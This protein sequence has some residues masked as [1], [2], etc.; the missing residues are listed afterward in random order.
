MINIHKGQEPK[1]LTE[2]RHTAAATYDD[3][4]DKDTLRQF[5]VAE[6]RGLCCYC[7]RSISPHRNAMKIE[8]WHPQEDPR[9]DHEQL[10]YRNLLA[11]C[12][13][14]DGYRRAIRHCDTAKGA[15]LLSRNPSSAVE[16]FQ[17]MIQYDLQGTI[18]ATD[19]V[20]SN[21][22]GEV[23]NL[24]V[25]ELKSIRRAELRA[26]L[27]GVKIR[28]AF[29]KQQLRKIIDVWSGS[30]DNGPLRPYCGVILYWAQKRLS[31][32]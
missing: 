22:L 31:R 5:L 32:L 21:E 25:E 23:L 14:G 11:S 6:Q 20:F 8:H 2:Y 19:P 4:R 24:N 12:L 7:M 17:K 9:C 27:M 18:T 1:S 29:T 13:G 3:Y 26:F 15:K 10:D 30:S 16:N 28:G